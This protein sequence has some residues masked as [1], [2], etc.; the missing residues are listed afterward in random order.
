MYER[1]QEKAI[2]GR[3]C[4][5]VVGRVLEDYV[6]GQNKEFVEAIEKSEDFDKVDELPNE[7]VCPECGDELIPKEGCYSC[8]GCGYSD[9]S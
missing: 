6:S 1:G 9:C 4:P 5:D 2:K 7:E 8:P 3:S